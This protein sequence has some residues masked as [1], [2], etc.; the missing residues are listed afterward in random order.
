MT[1]ADR[2]RIKRNELQISQSELAI[3]A[4]YSDRTAISKFEN[5]GNDIT[6]KQVKRVATA[7]GVSTAY[8]MGW[9]DIEGNKTPHGQLV[10]A[11][12]NKQRQEK[13]NALYEQYESLPPDKQAQFENFLKFLQS[14]VELPHLKKNTDQ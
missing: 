10:D 7:L 12:A 4:G 5:A 1:I 14:D 9:E 3:R 8:L 6:M 2:I 11:Y 13:A